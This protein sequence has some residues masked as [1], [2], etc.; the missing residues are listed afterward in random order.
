MSEEEPKPLF[1]KR[2]ARPQ[3]RQR[4]SEDPPDETSTPKEGR[5]RSEEADE[6]KLS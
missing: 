6:E 3:P 2:T 1:K 4:P 5:E